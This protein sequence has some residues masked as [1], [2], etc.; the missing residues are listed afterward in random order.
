MA[1]SFYSL[2]TNENYRVGVSTA[3]LHERLHWASC[4]SSPEASCHTLSP[5]QT[6]GYKYYQ[7]A[8]DPYILVSSLDLS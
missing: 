7:H 1:E 6:L 3:T 5:L 4:P 8:T 2:L